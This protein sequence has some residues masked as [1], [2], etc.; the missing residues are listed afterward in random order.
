MKVKWIHIKLPLLLL[1]V[2]F[3]FSFTANRNAARKMSGVEIEFADSNQLFITYEMVNKL[4]IQNQADTSGV[5]KDELDLN[6]LEQALISNDMIQNAHVYLTVNGQLGAKVKQR[7]PIARVNTTVPFYIDSEGKP[8]P[9]S[10]VFSARVPIITGDVNKND[11][12]ETF[13][14]SEYIQNDTFL[15]KHVVGIHKTGKSFE[16]ELRVDEFV[17]KLG[18]LENLDKKFFNFKAFYQKAIKDKSLS[19]YEAVNLKFNNQVVCT[20]K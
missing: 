15:K 11:L 18:D 16:L 7:K 9:L 14:L 10:G 4:L 8:M 12:D 19:E 20:K 5:R 13:E 17:V 6:I 3:L 2:V 1:L